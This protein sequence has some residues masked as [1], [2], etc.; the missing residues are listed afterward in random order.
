MMEFFGKPQDYFNKVKA[1][2]R[3]PIARKSQPFDETLPVSRE[4]HPFHGL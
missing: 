1:A 2:D 3:N 4:V